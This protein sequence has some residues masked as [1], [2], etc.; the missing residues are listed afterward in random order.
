MTKLAFHDISRA[1]DYENY[2][3][4]TSSSSDTE[5]DVLNNKTSRKVRKN[6]VFRSKY[7]QT[8]MIHSD[9]V[10]IDTDVDS[11]GA[12]DN[13]TEAAD[14]DFNS[15]RDFIKGYFTQKDEPQ[16]NTRLV[17]SK[18]PTRIYADVQS[19]V[20]ECL[21]CCDEQLLSK[22][23]CCGFLSCNMCI[24]T[25]IQTQIMKSCGSIKIECLNSACTS[26]F[27]KAE[28][29]ERMTAFDKNSLKV[30]LKFL[31]DSNKNSSCK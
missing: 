8:M 15:R 16:L 19:E 12:N 24:D 28:I 13:V 1:S 14:F 5:S 18:R 22:Q 10:S 30:Y 17:T 11:I 4:F 9:E 29:I 23:S 25:Y 20:M 7:R 31:V 3:S 27:H 26:L 21:I 2:Q 6:L